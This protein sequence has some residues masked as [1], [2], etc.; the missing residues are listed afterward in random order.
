ILGATSMKLEKPYSIRDLA[1]IDRLPDGTKRC[2]I[3]KEVKNLAEFRM[4]NSKG[5]SWPNYACIP[6]SRDLWRKA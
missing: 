3:C 5:K 2:R 1:T 6:C 4:I